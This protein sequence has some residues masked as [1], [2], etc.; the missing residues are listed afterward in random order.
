MHR[1]R[2]KD[3]LRNKIRINKS[4]SIVIGDNVKI[5]NS[6]IQIKGK[7]NSLEIKDNS[8][9]REVDIFISG[10]NNSLVIGK[11]TMI[12]HNTSLTVKEGT[13]L[14]IGDNCMLSRNIKILTSDGHPVFVDDK[15]INIALDIEIGNKVWLA[16]SV[17]VFKGTKIGDGSV[18]GMQSM[19]TRSIGEK[20]VA[21]GTPCKVIK[22]NIEWQEPLS[23]VFA[24]KEVQ[25]PLAT[26]IISVYKD[27]ENLKLIL[28]SLELQS[29]KRFEVIVSEDNDGTEMKQFLKEYQSTF[30][31]IHLSQPDKGF[32][33]NR[34]LN[35]AIKV[36]N[37][38]YLVFIDGDCIPNEKFIEH[39]IG[40][41]ESDK[42]LVGRR[43]M[44]GLKLSQILLAQGIKKFR[45][46]YKWLIRTAHRDNVTF[47]EEGIYSFVG[48]YKN[49]KSILGCNFSC[50]K[51]A[52]ESI[53][54]FDED[55]EK[56]GFGE[57]SDIDWRL[58][59]NGYT[60]KSVRNLAI[61]YHIDHPLGDNS[62]NKDLYLQKVKEHHVRCLNGL[63]KL[64]K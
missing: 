37:T 17:V 12:G 46:R 30:T 51:K 22:E 58:Q 57:D 7:N 62:Q 32:R 13:R 41:S 14:L 64:D 56:S 27:I 24:Q 29:D 23:S 63:E 54:G 45:Q 61:V 59:A 5:T 19:V 43:P 55:Y 49:A 9:L 21:V 39:H 52:L 48:K 10:N 6:V 16:D 1:F 25:K 34:A 38:D 15:R 28:D 47:Y 18:I 31:I 4:S 8:I 44:L 50:S 36:S 60:L 33:K 40:M 11:N 20:V 42:I 3:Y 53:N 35:R 26:L 2:F